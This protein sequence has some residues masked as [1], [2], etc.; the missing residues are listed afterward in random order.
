MIYCEPCGCYVSDNILTQ[1]NEGRK[2]LRKIAANG[3]TVTNTVPPHQRALLGLP[4]PDPRVKVSHEDGLD[5]VEGEGIEQVILIERTEEFSSLSFRVNKPVVGARTPASWCALFD[6]SIRKSHALL[7]SFEVSLPGETSVVRRRKPRRVLVSFQPP[8][9]GTFHMFLDIIFND[10]SVPS[11]A[12]FVVRRELRG[13]AVPSSHVGNPGR[14][15]LIP[16]I[17]RVDDHAS[18]S[19]E[20]VLLDSQGSGISVSHEGG[21][22]FGIVDCNGLNGRFEGSAWVTID[23]AVGFPAVTFVEARIISLDGSD[24]R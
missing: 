7:G 1:H 11:E 15:Q 23:H 12:E 18:R 24:S 16:G 4:N 2:H 21:V 14:R 6:D 20:D 8:H 3:T 22:D 19:T 9:A 13:R 10:S 17:N 5:F